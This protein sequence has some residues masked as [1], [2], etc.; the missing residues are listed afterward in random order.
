MRKFI[1]L[2]FSLRFQ[3]H[4]YYNCD[5]DNNFAAISNEFLDATQFGNPGINVTHLKFKRWIESCLWNLDMNGLVVYLTRVQQISFRFFLTP[6]DSVYKQ[7][8]C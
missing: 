6:L 3:V 7:E 8:K 4:K 1:S 5:F 2:L